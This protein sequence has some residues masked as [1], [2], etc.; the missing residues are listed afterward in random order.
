[1][2]DTFTFRIEPELKAAF[3]DLAEKQNR[4]AGE[5]LRDFIRELVKTKR[6]VDFVREARRQSKI[7]AAA[8]LDSGGDEAQIMRELDSAFDEFSTS[9]D[10][11]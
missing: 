10:W 3:A 5:I 1:M 11:Q 8:T 9:T 2:M 4:H 6:K 7:I